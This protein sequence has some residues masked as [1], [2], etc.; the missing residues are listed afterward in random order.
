MQ[1]AGALK[2]A[3]VVL[4]PVSDSA[5]RDAEVLLCH[6][7]GESLTYLRTWPERDLS[8]EQQQAYDALI[9][10]R[11]LGEPVAYLTGEREFWSLPFLVTSDT[12]IPRPETE[13]LVEKTLAVLPAGAAQQVLDLG[14]GSGV[15]ALSLAK[16][17]PH[18]QLTATDASF[19]ALRIAEKNARR[20]KLNNVHFEY[21]SWFAPVAGRRYHAIISN[22]PYVAD[23]DPHLAQGDVRFEPSSALVSG[24][25]GLDDIRSIVTGAPAH[26]E[27]GGWL[28]LEH[29]YDQGE[30][31]AALLRAAGFAEVR[32][33]PDLAGQPRVTL[34][35]C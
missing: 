21:G 18:W 30:A 34:G 28:L 35:H 29:G 6:V 14:T 5:R 22:P 32:T 11:Q 19:A 31:V 17:R 2:Q 15:I 1:I 20:L 7:L 13:L 24:S 12:L 10:K 4:A 23:R 9:R 16:E 8:S 26:L 27:P 3:D 25:D 33:L